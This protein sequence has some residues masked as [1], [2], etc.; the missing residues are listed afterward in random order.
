MINLQKI[1]SSLFLISSIFFLLYIYHRSSINFQGINNTYYYQFYIFAFI[2]FLF[3]LILFKL[4]K[5]YFNYSV[6]YFFIMLFSLYLF[7]GFLIYKNRI[8]ALDNYKKDTYFNK[9]GKKY[10]LRTKIEIWK[11]LNLLYERVATKVSPNNLNY[12]NLTKIFPLAGKS[13]AKTIYGN[14]NGYYFIFQSDRFGFNN[15][16]HEWDHNN[17]DFIITGDSYAFGCCVNRPNDI[18]SLMR[19]EGKNIVLNLAYS[20]NGP[21]IEY[22]VLKEYLKNKNFNK[23]FWFYFEGND[24]SGFRSEIA[25]PLLKKYLTNPHYTQSLLT[26]Q[27]KIDNIVSKEIEKALKIEENRLKNIDIKKNEFNIL[28]FELISFL[29]LTYLRMSIPIQ[30]I[31]FHSEPQKELFQVLNLAKNLAKKNNADFNF[32]YLPE[33]RRYKFNNYNNE[34]YLIIKK[35]LKKLNINIIDIHENVFKKQKN[36]LKLFPFELGDGHY[37][38]LGYR[39]IAEHILKNIE[40]EKN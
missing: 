22:A 34:N 16:D 1:I 29:R 33:Y 6:F 10:D 5:R 39:L 30:S 37:N 15:P 23:I 24:I 40:Y 21:L 9:T 27:N 12:N 2:F 28:K 32:V 17:I 14:E 38:E 19:E 4:N 7:E 20:H 26:N 18:A 3:S 25:N 11:D 13:N 36:P 31:K 8:S 35:E